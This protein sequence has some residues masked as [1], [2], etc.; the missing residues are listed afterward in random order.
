MDHP[1]RDIGPDPRLNGSGVQLTWRQRGILAVVAAVIGGALVLLLLGVPWAAPST[2]GSA[3][4]VEPYRL[5]LTGAGRATV[6]VEQDGVRDR[7]VEA[8]LPDT[9]AIDRGTG[10]V[11]AEARLVGEDTGPG[12]ACAIVDA[13][14]EVVQRAR[15]SGD[16]AAVRCQAV[17]P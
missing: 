13:T 7:P 10:A 4:A 6:T 9:V 14:G 11:E 8:A 15:A 5:E 17:L 2:P 1:R 16:D 12:I 3:P